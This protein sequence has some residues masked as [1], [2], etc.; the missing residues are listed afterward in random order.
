MGL[1]L[2]ALAVL[3]LRHYPGGGLVFAA[4]LVINLG[5]LALAAPKPRLYGYTFLATFFFLGFCAKTVA[6]FAL[7]IPMVEPTGHFD[8]SGRA[9]D[10]SLEP[11]I[12]GAA[13]IALIRFVHLMIFR[14]RRGVASLGHPPPA[15]YVRWRLPVVIGSVAAI[16]VLNAINLR[17]AFYQ[18]GVS[19]RVILPL[20]LSVPVEWLFVSGLSLWAA[21]L[22]GWEAGMAGERLGPALLL[23]MTEALASVSTLSRAAYLFRALPYVL[24][25]I[26]NPREFLSR[27]S[28][29]WLVF[30]VAALPAGLLISVAAVSLLR[31][32]IYPL[33]T[34]TGQLAPS[35]RPIST[36]SPSVAPPQPVV[37]P[38]AKP[39]LPPVGED[40]LKFVGREVG[41]SVVGRWIGIEGTMAVSSYPGRNMNL[42]FRALRENPAAG[43]SAI[44]QQI[45]GSSYQTTSQ[46]VFL[47]TPGAIA[48][49]YY[50][51]SLL[52]VFVGMG[53]LTALLIAFELVA[54]N[55]LANGLTTS[56]MAIALAN[57]IAQLNFPYLLAVLFLE[58]AVAVLLLSF[59]DGG[60]FKPIANANVNMDAPAPEI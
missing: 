14:N 44:Y 27:L 1:T 31:L 20:H 17:L 54:S 10:A 25:V 11:A 50:S 6:N 32:A 24:V 37:I 36:A 60:L 48:V 12:A 47:T 18:I 22:I 30:F 21:T 56:I 13:A 38:T 5:M 57:A 28:K 40:R 19:P 55:R 7:G 59:I 34:Q 2:L 35:G 39:I 29:K 23:A 53:L 51:G 3:A 58:Q 8:G 45:S 43:E 4:F 49:L 46:Y 33:I 16:L 26:E 52:V 41:L 42:L 9:W 15:M